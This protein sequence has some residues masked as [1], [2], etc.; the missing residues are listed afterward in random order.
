M[1][2]PNCHRDADTR[3]SSSLFVHTVPIPTPAEITITINI[4]PDANIDRHD[5]HCSDQ[6]TE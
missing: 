6:Q 1:L 4:H 2:A 5:A 3:T